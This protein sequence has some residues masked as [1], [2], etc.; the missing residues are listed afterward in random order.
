MKKIT[1]LLLCGILVTTTYQQE[2]LPAPKPTQICT[3]G[4]YGILDERTKKIT[5][6]DC[7]PG[8]ASCKR[9]KANAR[10]IPEIC[11]AFTTNTNAFFKD[12]QTCRPCHTHC[13]ECKGLELS[14]C[15]SLNQ[16]YFYN[17]KTK[18]IEKKPIGCFRVNKEGRCRL[19]CQDG[20]RKDDIQN[21]GKPNESFTCKPCQ[22]PN[23]LECVHKSTFLGLD[24]E[25]CTKC[26][27]D[28][29]GAHGRC[30]KSIEH[31]AKYS[32]ENRCVRCNSGYQLK[33]DDKGPGGSACIK[34]LDKN[35]MLYNEED[36]ECGF[37]GRGTAK[38]LEGPNKG[39]CVSCNS[40]F[41]GCSLCVVRPQKGKKDQAKTGS[42]ERECFDCVSGFWF[43]P[44]TQKCEHIE[45]EFCDFTDKDGKSCITCL[46]GFMIS[47]EGKCIKGILEG[48]D[49]YAKNDKLHCALCEVGWFQTPEK[50]C[51]KCHESC[52]ACGGP[53]AED[54]YTCPITKYRLLTHN[55]EPTGGRASIFGRFR[56]LTR[57]QCVDKCPKVDGVDTTPE[58]MNGH[59]LVVKKEENKKNEKKQVV[60]SHE[61][62]EFG[63]KIVDISEPHAFV[64]LIREFDTKLI[65]YALIDL[66]AAQLLAPRLRQH[67]EKRCSYRGWLKER[68][69]AERETYFECVCV[70]DGIG[71]NCEFSKGLYEAAN[72]Y[73][74]KVLNSVRKLKKKEA[75]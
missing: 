48:C 56:R 64:K 35:C 34:N 49:V 32:S 10:I 66:R 30:V 38:E 45:D 67:L 15:H 61:R 68:L 43:N 74:A 53:K 71:R 20:F 2:S 42:V 4:Q 75:N 36:N 44:K 69:S 13:Q 3:S 8:M 24:F 17:R 73:V 21:A 12:H 41:E 26:E 14:Q 27:D 31:C 54:C 28:S 62:Y 50:K 22:V 52:Y 39:K 58:D 51:Q 37:C 11:E 55:P 1:L 60:R 59:C 65:R 7:P 72:R 23:C 29:F 9:Y 63:S 16:D 70:E 6:H 57:G 5:C 47:N 19:S 25:L 40:L 46:S 18:K 33:R